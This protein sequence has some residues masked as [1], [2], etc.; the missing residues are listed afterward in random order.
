MGVEQLKAINFPLVHGIEVE[1][2][3]VR[4]MPLVHGIEA[5]QYASYSTALK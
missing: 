3:E 2:L 1:K 4:A 5:E